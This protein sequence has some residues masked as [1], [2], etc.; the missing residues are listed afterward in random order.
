[1]GAIAGPSGKE[2]RVDDKK[3][4][5]T[6]IEGELLKCET[7]IKDLRG[8]PKARTAEAEIG[9]LETELKGCRIALDGL[10]KV[11]ASEWEQAKNDVVKRL[12]NLSKK[13]DT[14]QRR[15]I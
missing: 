4:V 1:V 9:G 15:F 3:K 5:T 10:L 2:R 13:L 6:E 12:R 11:R 7:R 14:T 8:S